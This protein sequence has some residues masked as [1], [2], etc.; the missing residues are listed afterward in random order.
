VHGFFG[1]AG[2]QYEH[3]PKSLETRVDA[4]GEYRLCFI[5]TETTIYLHATAGD[6]R[7]LEAPIRIPPE[8]HFAR[9]DLTLDSNLEPVTSIS[10]IVVGD[11]T[12]GPIAGAELAL[13]E[14][15]LFGATDDRGMLRLTEVALGTH[16]LTIRRAGFAP[17]DTTIMIAKAK[18]VQ[19]RFLLHAR[20][21]N[22]T[23]EPASTMAK[24]HDAP[25]VS[26]SRDASRTPLP[27][28]LRA[29][30]TASRECSPPSATPAARRA[31]AAAA[32]AR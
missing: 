22:S 2:L 26:E 6:I 31:R 15:S 28:P 11:S 13:P 30:E 5:P 25:T 4:A 32:C 8:L 12:V 1:A 19:I 29:R 21:S 17:L 18:P 24:P 7:A 23:S 16:K 27:P 14:L 20:S 10:A 3:I 9:V